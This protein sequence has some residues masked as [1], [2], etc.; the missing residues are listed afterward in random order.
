MLV[1]IGPLLWHFENN[2]PGA[3][4]RERESSPNPSNESKGT[5]YHEYFLIRANG[6]TSGIADPGSVE[7]T[8]D[9]VVALIETMGFVVEK[10]VSGIDAPYIQD[11]ESMLQNTYKASHWVARKQ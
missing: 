9:E 2:A 10:K 7:L 5:Y 3:H 4:G 11:P 1:N 8:D 6:T